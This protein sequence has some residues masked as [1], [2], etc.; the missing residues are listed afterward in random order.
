[1]GLVCRPGSSRDPAGYHPGVTDKYGMRRFIDIIAEGEVIDLKQHK[2]QKAFGDYATAVQGIYAAEA[3]FF[4]RGKFSPFA[5]S[6]IESG[7]K[8][9]FRPQVGLMVYFRDY[10][11][12]PVARELLTRL[13]KERPKWDIRRTKYHQD[14]QGTKSGPVAHLDDISLER[15]REIWA[16]RNESEFG[17]YCPSRS[18][19]R[20]VCKEN[21][22]ENGVGFSMLVGGQDGRRGDK[23]GNATRE[24]WHIIDNDE[25]MK[26][27][28]D[29]FAI[30][31]R[32]RMVVK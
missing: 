20:T 22:D 16:N 28:V 7:F 25:E 19:F 21:W 12:T 27:V 5:H 26:E 29:M 6:Y 32:A 14:Y 1:M 23:Y 8:E 10:R 4:A 2:T 3:D 9:E 11:L 30:I 13:T 31:R 24:E 17:A 18:G 15:A